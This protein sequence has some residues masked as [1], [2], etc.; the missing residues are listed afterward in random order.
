EAVTS[1]TLTPDAAG[2]SATTPGGSAY[3]VTPSAATGTGGFDANNYNI[4]YTPYN[5]TVAK[6]T[7][8]VTVIVGTYI[9]DGLSQGPNSV[10]DPAVGGGNAPTGTPTFVYVG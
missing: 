4:T 5:G 6:A 2:L 7:E 3:V 1:V 10:T 9:Y 8:T